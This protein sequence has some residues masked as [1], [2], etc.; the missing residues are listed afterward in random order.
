MRLKL[1]GVVHDADL[2]IL[3]YIFKDEK[4][5]SYW[6]NVGPADQPERYVNEM[7]FKENVLL[8]PVEYAEA[9][10]SFR[11]DSVEKQARKDAEEKFARS[12]ADADAAYHGL[13]GD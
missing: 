7:M 10:E 4:G 6:G 5:R 3:G 2:S 8:T 12:R 9:L 11:V 1:E 13:T